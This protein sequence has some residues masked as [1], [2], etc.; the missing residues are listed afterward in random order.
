MPNVTTTFVVIIYAKNPFSL[1]TLKPFLR[2][3]G[4]DTLLSFII[5]E[6]NAYS[7]DPTAT[8]VN[9]SFLFNDNG[10]TPSYI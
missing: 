2:T 6:K 8:V 10:D 3:L 5:V 7:A 4:T 1:S 9:V